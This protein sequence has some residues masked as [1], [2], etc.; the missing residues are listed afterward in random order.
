MLCSKC[1][2]NEAVA[3][4]EQVINGQKKETNLCYECAQEMQA[5]LN[6]MLYS[7]LFNSDLYTQKEETN[8][9]KCDFCGL[10]YDEFK[11]IGKLGCADCYKTFSKEL[12][13]IF[14]NIQDGKEHVGKVPRSSGAILLRE[15]QLQNLKKSLRKAIDDEEYEKAAKLRDQIKELETGD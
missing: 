3:Y 13:L 9:L 11:K 5:S 6:N 10:T 7:F 8:V 1:K 14:N 2:K 15:R 12:D 4:F